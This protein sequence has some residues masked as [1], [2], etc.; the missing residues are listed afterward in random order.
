MN[1]LLWTDVDFDS[2]EAW[3]GFSLM[4]GTQHQTVYQ[5][6]MAKDL[7]PIYTDVFTFP[8]E[9]NADFMLDHW[10]IHQSN[11]LLLGITMPYDL[12]SADLN[13]RGQYSD[14][15]AQHA[16]IHANENQTLGIT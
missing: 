4:H 2:D 12:S 1:S 6:I 7:L 16:I 13:D 10:R 9:D 11:A 14:W 15:L 8:R 5:A 3:Q